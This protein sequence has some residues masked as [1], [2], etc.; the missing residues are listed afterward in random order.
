MAVQPSECR[1]T[2]DGW[3]QESKEPQVPLCR[4]IYRRHQGLLDVRLV[5]E[6][7]GRPVYTL[8]AERGLSGNPD[9]QRGVGIR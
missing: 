9:I 3:K 1:E 2:L 8:S 7:A 4:Q 5:Q 6:T